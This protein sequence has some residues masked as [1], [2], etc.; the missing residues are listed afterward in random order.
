MKVSATEQIIRL[1]FM[2]GFG[3]GQIRYSSNQNSTWDNS[4]HGTGIEPGSLQLKA[5]P[6]STQTTMFKNIIIVE[7]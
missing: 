3:H 1:R 4:Q 6:F 5:G 2:K 7:T